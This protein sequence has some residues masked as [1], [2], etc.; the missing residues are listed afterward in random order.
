MAGHIW[1]LLYSIS[2]TKYG[3][4][5][6]LKCY[7][8]LLIDRIFPRGTLY[9]DF[10]VFISRHKDNTTIPNADSLLKHQRL[11]IRLPYDGLPPLQTMFGSKQSMLKN[12]KLWILLLIILLIRILH[13]MI[14]WRI[15]SNYQN[16]LRTKLISFLTNSL[17]QMWWLV[18]KSELGKCQIGM[19]E[20]QNFIKWIIQSILMRL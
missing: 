13:T 7:V 4:W 14:F 19:K 8:V 16:K 11:L 5:L 6:Y 9:F 2:S 15:I 17:F 18:C 12:W 20:P 1:I 10:G 3:C